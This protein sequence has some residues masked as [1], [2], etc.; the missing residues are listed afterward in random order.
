MIVDVKFH[1]LPKDLFAEESI[2]NSFIRC[3][4][5]A[6]GEYVKLATIPGTTWKQAIVSKPQGYENLNFNERETI[7]I[8]RI[9]AINEA[10]VDKA[11]LR[12]P[13]WQ[14]W[15]TLD[16]CKQ[17]NNELAAS[18]REHPDRFLGLAV[19]PPWGDKDCLYELERCVKD[20]GFRGVEVAAHY[21][22]LYLDDER[23][24]PYLK[25]LNDLGVTV[26]VHHTPLPVEYNYIYQYS[27]VR[28]FYGRCIDQMTALT[29]ILFSGLLEELPNIK[30]IHTM[31]GGGFF[32]YIN[33]LLP[34]RT[35][36]QEDIQRFDTGIEK[37]RGYLARNIYFDITH[38]Q[39][40]GKAQLECAVKTLGADH[41]V[42]GSSYPLRHEWLYKG[43]D[44]IRSLEIGAKE[45]ELIL[46]ENAQMLFKIKA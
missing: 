35:G 21:G 10:K 40:W 30:L 44:Y 12:M 38:A 23:F 45:K 27:N 31:L 32:A 1:W 17:V 34:E 43:A 13:C 46:G 9:K 19:I 2:F 42:W 20:L 11:I 39:P 14:E 25:K 26:C 7:S 33:M 29:R 16:L 15:L 18:V 3:V 28:R 6:Y 37:I 8:D 4:P 41:I 5:Q 36:M 24:R 22:N